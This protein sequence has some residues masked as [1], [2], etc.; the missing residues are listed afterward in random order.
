[1]TGSPANASTASRYAAACSSSDGG[2]ARSRNRNSVR[3]RPTPRAP[4]A[5]A[6]AAS[7]GVA[8][9]REQ[10]D[11][12]AVPRHGGQGGLRQVP[13]PGRRVPG[14]PRVEVGD[15]RRVGR[16][17]DLARRAVDGGLRVRARRRERRE[18]A[19]DPD[20]RRDPVGARQDRGV[21]R[22]RPGLE[23]D[24]QHVL[25]GQRGG[26]RRGQVVRDDDGRG[27]GARRLLGGQTGEQPRDP[28]RHVH[29]VGRACGQHLVVEG[30]Q[31]RRNVRAGGLDR[32]NAVLAQVP[33]TGRRHV[34]Q[35]RVP[36]HRR[37]GHEDRGLVL[38]A[39]GAHALGQPMRSSAAS[40]AASRRRVSSA[41]AAP[42]ATRP[43]IGSSRR[44]T[45]THDPRA[46]PG[47]AA[48]PLILRNPV[49]VVMP[50]AS[51]SR[52]LAVGV[53]TSRTAPSYRTATRAPA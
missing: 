52:S 36:G 40:L 1:M 51:R 18:D 10:R 22:G 14:G 38:V 41:S 13:G 8:D 48:T 24:P 12:H 42:G 3:N 29:D 53:P 19:A 44:R 17:H 11:L 30:G 6:G 43:P 35:R 15:C 50:R 47:A 7:P 2:V 20:H 5:R 4:S 33:D 28:V 49:P 46:T 39:V 31:H 9:V 26:E 23:H 25:A 34:D 27:R 37:V 45:C 21:R 32:R 16:D